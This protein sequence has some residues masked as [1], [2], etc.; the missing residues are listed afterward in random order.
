MKTLCNICIYQGY[1]DCSEKCLMEIP[2]Q[3]RLIDKDVLYDACYK[4]FEAFANGEIDGKTALLN[5]EREIRGADY[6]GVG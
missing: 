5:I 1:V 3:K 6:W 2:P 4:H